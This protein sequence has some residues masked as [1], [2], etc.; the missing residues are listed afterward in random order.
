M[1]TSRVCTLILFFETVIFGMFVTAVASGSVS[2]L[3][4]INLAVFII[5]ANLSE[6]HTSGTA[7]RRCVCI[8]TTVLAAIYRKS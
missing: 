7:L 1:S 4:A 6:P 8:Y 5:G 3:L 2:A